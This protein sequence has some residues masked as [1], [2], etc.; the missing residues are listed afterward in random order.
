MRPL[1]VADRLAIATRYARRTW[2]VHLSIVVIALGVAARLHAYADN[3]ALWRDEGMLAMNVIEH[4]VDQFLEPLDYRQLTPVGFLLS[5]KLATSLF[6]EGE[7]ALRLFPLLAGLAALPLTFLV[8]GRIDGRRS[9]WR[10]T[11]LVAAAPSAIYFSTEAKQYA[12]DILL[13]L[14]AL[15]LGLH[16]AR[17]ALSWRSGAALAV[18]GAVMVWFSHPVALVLGGVGLSLIGQALAARR[19]PRAWALTAICALW[20]IS[21]AVCVLATN[22]TG[23][24]LGDQ[25]AWARP[26]FQPL[27]PHSLDDLALW[28]RTLLGLPALILQGGKGIGPTEVPLLLRMTMLASVV[29]VVGLAALWRKDRWVCAMML[30]PFVLM[31]LVSMLE[32]YPV[33]ARLAAFLLP[34]LVVTVAI[35]LSRAVRWRGHFRVPGMALALGFLVLPLMHTALA[36][37]RPYPREELRAVLRHVHRGERGRVDRDGQDRVVAG[38]DEIVDRG[39]LGGDVGAGRDDL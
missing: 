35:A 7:R 3:R 25:D 30:S 26:G 20:L 12:Y 14:I 19:W 17:S 33:F 23:R 6:G 29:W 21:F 10:A 37:V 34:P 31:M 22:S 36:A 32:I 11:A 13:S 15:W 39:H 18:L 9:A 1:L 28:A 27:P 24:M 16:A 5:V 8:T 2:L 38:V 4:G